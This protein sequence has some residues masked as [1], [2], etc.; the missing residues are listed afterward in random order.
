[1]I[2]FPLPPEDQ[3][4]LTQLGAQL[5]AMRRKA[6]SSELGSEYKEAAK[7]LE[8]FTKFLEKKYAKS[9]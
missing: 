5:V 8:A 9:R 2:P 7:N 1:M 4:Q 3:Q 6:G